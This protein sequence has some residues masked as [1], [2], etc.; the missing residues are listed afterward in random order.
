MNRDRKLDIS[1]GRSLRRTISERGNY[2]LVF[3]LIVITFIS[4]MVGTVDFVEIFLFGMTLVLTIW[5]SSI[6]NR[7]LYFGWIACGF[8]FAL[9]LILELKSLTQWIWLTRSLG[10][11]LLLSTAAAIWSRLKRYQTVGIQ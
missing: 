7:L 4:M 2:E 1:P 11:V 5:I 8:C 9:S 3:L 10:A 6:S